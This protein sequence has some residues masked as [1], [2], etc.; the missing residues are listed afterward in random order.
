VPKRFV[1]GHLE[2]NFVERVQREVRR[3]RWRRRCWRCRGWGRCWGCRVLHWWRRGWRWGRCRLLGRLASSCSLR[4]RGA[5]L[6]AS[7]PGLACPGSLGSRECPA[8]SADS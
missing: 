6:P 3:G 7:R 1:S 2:V 8:R 5:A 4:R